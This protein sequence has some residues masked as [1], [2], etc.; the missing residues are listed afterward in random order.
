[1]LERLSLFLAESPSSRRVRFLTLGLG[2]VALRGYLPTL[3]DF[4][5]IFGEDGPA[6]GASLL[7]WGLDDRVQLLVLTLLFVGASGMMLHVAPRAAT[8]L[9][10][11]SHS[12][13]WLSN[14]SFYWSW[15][16]LYCDFL[17][18]LVFFAT[19]PPTPRGR[20]VAGFWFRMFQVQVCFV[21][22]LSSLYR[23]DSRPWLRGEAFH[24]AMADTVFG[25]FTSLNWYGYYPFTAPLSYGAWATEWMGG[26][27]L[28]FNES[29][30]PLVVL[31]LTSMHIVLELTTMVQAWQFLMLT[32]L[33]AFW[34]ERWFARI[35]AGAR[36]LVSVCCVSVGSMT[37][38]SSKIPSIV[39]LAVWISV[40]VAN[41]PVNWSPRFIGASRK[42]LF[43][44][45][46][47]VGLG[48][49]YGM[50]MF[51]RPSRRGDTC[52]IVIGFHDD[53]RRSNLLFRPPVEDCIDPSVHLFQN[54]GHHALFKYVEQLTRPG[55]LY[56][57]YRKGKT[58][59]DFRMDLSEAFCRRSRS[60]GHGVDETYV[61]M[62]RE[63][64]YPEYRLMQ[65]ATSIER[66]RRLIRGFGYD[67]NRHALISITS[68]T[69]FADLERNHPAMHEVFRAYRP[70]SSSESA[71]GR[72]SAS[73]D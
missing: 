15:G 44:V 1:M 57:I 22:L 61:G 42:M 54:H 17:F 41:V 6:R 2:L 55:S 34:P 65:R 24:M 20:A 73:H 38:Q 18:F 4:L 35:E 53:G 47:V 51:A 40:F 50:R 67:C 69:V 26:L 11:L 16:L 29:L 27:F 62:F 56:R 8:A 72:A 19:P 43:P 71:P 5:F 48:G 9:V 30:G 37:G 45:H 63:T 13:L 25:R 59:E 49:T 68:E 23:Y 58:P 7:P 28:L 12:W 64:H 3:P 31:A 66:V 70:A 10:W 52:M 46:A 60:G 36:R 14:S 33:M 39:F 21:Y 32:A